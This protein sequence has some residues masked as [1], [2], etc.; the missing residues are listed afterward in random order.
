MKTRKLLFALAT[1]CLLGGL[2]GCTGNNGADGVEHTVSFDPNYVSGSGQKAQ[3]MTKKVKHGE[4]VTDLPKVIRSDY[5]FMGW[6]TDKDV[7]E[8][9]INFSSTQ[10]NA[11]LFVYAKWQ[12]TPKPV[13]S[14]RIFDGTESPDS[15]TMTVGQQKT[16]TFVALPVDTTETQF[17]WESNNTDVVTVDQDGNVVAVAVGSTVISVSSVDNP[18]MMDMLDVTVT[19]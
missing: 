6:F 3:V 18:V 4:F 7:W 19:A 16:L 12:L 14:I 8:K 1:V 15:I 10:I 11:D 17:L 2:A 5:T 13:T 9:E